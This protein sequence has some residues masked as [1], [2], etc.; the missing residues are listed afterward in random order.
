MFHT[1]DYVLLMLMN[2]QNEILLLRR[3]NTDYGNQ[4]YSL[5]GGKIEAHETAR[6]AVIRE[7]KEEIGIDIAVDDLVFQHVVHRKG[8]E[9]EFF[10]FIFLA[11]KWKGAP[12]NLEPE[13]HDD[14][15]WFSL[16]ALPNNFLP[17]HRQALDL[18]KKKITYSEH[19]WSH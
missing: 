9:T 13:K 18:I 5:I 17:A 2:T 1:H 7:A 4:D 12:A 3:I 16:D 10:S 6:Q 14:M 19:G 11:T 8:T 15:R